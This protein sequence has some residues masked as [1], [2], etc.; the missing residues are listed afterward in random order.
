MTKP[1]I[2]LVEDEVDL[3]QGTAAAVRHALPRYEVMEATTIEEAEE[4]VVDL[5]ASGEPL[6]LA[7]VDHQ[8]THVYCRD[9]D[10]VCRAAEALASESGVADV[11]PAEQ[12]FAPGP[13]R[14]RAGELVL[15]AREDAWF[16]DRWWLDPGYG[17]NMLPFRPA[18]MSPA[19]VEKGCLEA[20]RA[21]YRWGNI[22]RRG[23]RGA[24]RRGGRVRTLYY[25]INYLLKREVRERQ[26]YPLG[27]EGWRGE[28]VK[29]RE[30]GGALR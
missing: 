24:N 6:A 22:L 13:G 25:W 3:L 14:E 27:D 19:E 4:V 5:E 1:T 26:R 21:F 28:W 2:L 12:V 20:R 11:L 18:R 15:L 17:Y 16:Y 7:V 23:M 29:A 30:R 10:A 8:V 9:K